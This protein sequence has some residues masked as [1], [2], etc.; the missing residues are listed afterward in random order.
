[1]S[2]KQ[3]FFSETEGLIGI[4]E[5]RRGQNSSYIGCMKSG[6]VIS[7]VYVLYNNINSA[8]S[9]L[10]WVPLGMCFRFRD[11]VMALG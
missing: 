6:D 8:D 2:F 9:Y 1:M 3:F 5:R 4:L 11:V 10:K 7:E